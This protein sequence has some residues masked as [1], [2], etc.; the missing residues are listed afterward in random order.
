MQSLTNVWFTL[1]LIQLRL[2]IDRHL[3]MK[4]QVSQTISACSFYLRSIDQI[5]RFLSR[6]T[7]VH[8]VNAIIISRLD[9]CNAF[10]YGT[11]A[12]NIARVQL[13]HNSAARL[14]LRRSRSVS[15]TPLLRELH[16]L[17]IVFR[18]DFK[19]LVFTYKSMNNDAPVYL[20]ELVCPYQPTR[21][22][23]HFRQ[24]QTSTEDTFLSYCILV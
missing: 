13:T 14:I 21:T 7:K 6:P 18:D 5:S 11:S 20:C 23:R 24:F 12:V 19:L 15:A 3:D 10:L 17:L 9:Y 1:V 2:R 16:W 22:L 8:I 4:K